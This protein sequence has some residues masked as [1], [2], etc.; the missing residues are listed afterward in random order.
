MSKPLI[1]ENH[2]QGG[3]QEQ[4]LLQVDHYNEHGLDLTYVWQ[5]IIPEPTPSNQDMRDARN[6]A[7]NV[8]NEMGGRVIITV[9]DSLLIPENDRNAPLDANQTPVNGQYPKK[10][11]GDP[12]NQ[13]YTWKPL[14]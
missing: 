7:I 2:F 10:D 8:F 5:R 14:R 4:S 12:G 6:E 13:Y 11:T 1:K 3:W 9:L